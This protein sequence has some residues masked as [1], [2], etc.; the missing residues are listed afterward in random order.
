MPKSRPAGAKYVMLRPSSPVSPFYRRRLAVTSRTDGYYDTG[1][2]WG[3]WGGGV[4]EV[5]VGVRVL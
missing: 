3:L 5:G 4:A 1:W 2:R